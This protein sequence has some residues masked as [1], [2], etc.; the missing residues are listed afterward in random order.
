MAQRK[1]GG[2]GRGMPA[3]IDFGRGLEGLTAQRAD[4]QDVCDID[5]LGAVDEFHADCEVVRVGAT[6]FI[7]ARTTPVAYI[8]RSIHLA[9]GGD[10]HYQIQLL[11]EGALRGPVT[12]GKGDLGVH[13]TGYSSKI[14]LRAA[15]PG[16]HAHVLVWLV[17]RIL[18]APLVSFPEGLR[19]LR[20]AAS[21][22]YTHLLAAHLK[23]VWDRAPHC[24]RAEGEASVASLLALLAAGLR[25]GREKSASTSVAAHATQRNAIKRYLERSV[26]SVGAAE[27]DMRQLSRRFGLSRASLYR[28]FEPDGGLV[29]Y[30]RSRRL[31][32]AARLLVSPAHRHL[33]ILD[34]AIDCRFSSETSFIRSFRREYGISPG[35]LRASI[36]EHGMARPSSLAPLEWLRKIGGNAPPHQH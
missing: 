32:R 21:E 35:E 30:L 3:R 16:Q 36:G 26:V 23:E 7:L 2:V 19:G 34:I 28:L 4:T 14:E 13:D 15:A 20:F 22:P 6:L 5:P 24:T 9:R 29:T 25:P 8:R 33:R 18:L 27:L 1:S 31:H 17:P 12:L 11:L 10:D